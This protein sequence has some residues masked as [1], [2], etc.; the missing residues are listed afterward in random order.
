MQLKRRMTRASVW[1]SVLPRLQRT[2]RESPIF[3]FFRRHHLSRW[4]RDLLQAIPAVPWRD[5]L[6]RWG[7]SV[8]VFQVIDRIAPGPRAQAAVA[9]RVLVRSDQPVAALSL[10]TLREST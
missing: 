4:S 2:V 7:H 5:L 8:R 9:R 1:A 3:H 6:I 10:P